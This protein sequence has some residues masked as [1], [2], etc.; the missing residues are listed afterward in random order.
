MRFNIVRLPHTM[1]HRLRRVHVL[2]QSPRAPLRCMCGQRP[3][4]CDDLLYQR[5]TLGR[6]PAAA[7]RILDD[8]LNAAGEVAIPPCC[9]TTT[10]SFQL[11]GNHF[12][13]DT[14]GSNEDDFRLM[15]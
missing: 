2:C 7:V 1:N 4:R 5:I 3:S 15:H 11:L 9:N 12:V 6:V 8:A 10:C 13:L 14:L